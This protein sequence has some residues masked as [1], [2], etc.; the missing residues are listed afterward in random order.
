MKDTVKNKK[1][2]RRPRK[3]LATAYQTKKPRRQN[4]KELSILNNKKTNDKKILNK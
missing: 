1:T 4:V 2:S 3:T